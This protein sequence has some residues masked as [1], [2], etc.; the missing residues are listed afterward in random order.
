MFLTLDL[1]LVL[2]VFSILTP[3]YESGFYLYKNS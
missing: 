2:S 1:F 3:N